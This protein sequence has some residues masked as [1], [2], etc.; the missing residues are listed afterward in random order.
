M[1]QPPCTFVSG[2]FQVNGI[3]GTPAQS[4]LEDQMSCLVHWH[5]F[6]NSQPLQIPVRCPNAWELS[7]HPQ[8]IFTSMDLQFQSATNLILILVHL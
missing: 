5:N 2:I 7:Q 6:A 3:R 4:P 1:N 8:Q